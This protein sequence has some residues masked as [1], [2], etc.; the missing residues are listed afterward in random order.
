VAQQHG[1]HWIAIEKEWEYVELMVR[2]LGAEPAPARGGL[3]WRRR[4]A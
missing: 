1:R 3:L 2:R 4:A